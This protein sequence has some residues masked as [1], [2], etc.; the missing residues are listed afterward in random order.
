MFEVIKLRERAVRCRE[1]AKD[2]HPSV[3]APLFDMA[4]EFE[5]QAAH[6]ELQ[7][8]DR[9]KPALFGR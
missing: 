4:R 3:G 2:Y 5:R 8:I 9:R 7:G 6:M 1:I